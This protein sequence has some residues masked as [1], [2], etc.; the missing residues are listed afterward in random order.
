VD[1]VAIDRTKPTMFISPE[2]IWV[3]YSNGE[4]YNWDFLLGVTPYCC[5]ANLDL[6]TEL[7]LG[8]LDNKPTHVESFHLTLNQPM[9]PI[10]TSV[11]DDPLSLPRPT[12]AISAKINNLFSNPKF[13]GEGHVT[14]FTHLNQFDITRQNLKIVQDKEICRL[15]ILTF[16]G[17]IK[18]WFRTL[19]RKMIPSWKHFMEVFIATHED[20]VYD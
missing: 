11:W 16:K 8:G 1:W 9:A 6:S 15:F 20:Y 7:V 3:P 5:R 18:T 17:P 10:H 13:D 12:K 4:R 14:T 19:R 2:S